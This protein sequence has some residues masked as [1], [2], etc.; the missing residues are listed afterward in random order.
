MIIHRKNAKKVVSCE[1]LDLRELT[2]VNLQLSTDFKTL[3][4]LRLCGEI[5]SYNYSIS[6]SSRRYGALIPGRETNLPV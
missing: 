6:P 1:L 2:T 3:R 4:S 5:N